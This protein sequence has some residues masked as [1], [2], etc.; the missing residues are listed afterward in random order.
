MRSHN[1]SFYS[2]NLNYPSRSPWHAHFNPC[3]L[4]CI[5]VSDLLFRGTRRII[6]LFSTHIPT[7]IFLQFVIARRF[8]REKEEQPRGRKDATRQGTRGSRSHTRGR[9][10]LLSPIASSVSVRTDVRRHPRGS[11]KNTFLS[12]RRRC[13]GRSRRHSG[14]EVTVRGGVVHAKRGARIKVAYIPPLALSLRYFRFPPSGTC[15]YAYGEQRVPRS[16]VLR[17]DLSAGYSTRAR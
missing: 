2:R 14:P 3:L 16:A 5:R 9:V 17:N 10:S 11:R 6:R 7:V 1:S 15:G 12:A 8:N 4:R 13:S